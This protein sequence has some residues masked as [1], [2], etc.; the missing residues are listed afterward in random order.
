M[1]LGAYLVGLKGY[2]VGLRGYIGT[3]KTNNI[4]I[5]Y[6]EE[7]SKGGDWLPSLTPS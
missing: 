2:L 4:I 3:L 6:I 5:T 1:T 7:T